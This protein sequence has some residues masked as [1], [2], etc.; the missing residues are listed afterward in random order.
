MDRFS[1]A[2]LARRGLRGHR[3]AH[4][5]VA[6]GV[7]VATTV[8]VGA[9]VVGDSVR[10]SLRDLTLERLGA[11]DTAIVPG[12]LFR[13]ALANEAE[14]APLL[15]VPA[16][17]SR[18]E[19][20]QTKTAS[21]V[22]L[23]GCDER[24]FDLETAQSK[25]WPA[26]DDGAFITPAIAAELGDD[27]G[28]DLIVRSTIPTDLPADSPLGE[29]SDT[30]ASVR[31]K[32]EAVTSS[33]GLAR[34]ALVPSQGE[35]RNVFVPLDVAQQLLDA[36]GQCN[37]L[38][39]AGDLGVQPTLADYGLSLNEV[40]PGVWQ[41]ESSELVL[42]D[43]VEVAASRAFA[44]RPLVTANTYLANTIRIGER[45]IPYSTVA[46]VAD[47][48]ELSPATGLAD[49]EIAL[50]RWAADDLRAS[51]G[52]TVTL[53]YYEPE[54]THGVLREAEPIELRLARIV[55]LTD[56]SGEPTIAN[57][58]RWTPQL[59]GVT[60]A[61]SIN[62]WDLPF[63]LVET[64][65]DADEDYWDE[66]GTTPK[67]FV[68]LE[69]AKR[70]WGTRW[71]DTS[72]VRVAAADMPADEI[73]SKLLA[74]IDP[75]DLGFAPVPIKARG[76]AAASGSTP[77][78]VL[79]LLFSF[80]LIGAALLLIV[81]LVWLA[82]DGRRREL[83]VLGAVG[84]DR[85]T[86]RRLMRKEF[87]PVAAVGAL[88]GAALGVAYA[89]GL[90][91]LLRTV[92]IDAVGA[93]FLRLHAGA[94]PIIGG[95]IGAWLVALV[96]I[97]WALRRAT[98][99]SPKTLLA[100][101]G[102]QP[103]AA[104]DGSPRATTGIALACAALAGV[105]I[106]AGGSLR[107]E[108]AAGV[109]FA[110]GGLTLAA[111]L[112]SV[113]RMAS[114]GGSE[115]SSISL[116]RLA[117]QNVRRR[118]GRSLLTIGLI[119]AA[120]F[121]LLATSA[122]RLPP[123]DAG[124]GGFDLVAESDQP[125][126]YDLA[127]EDG[128]WELGFGPKAEDQLADAAIYSFRTHAGEDASCRNLYQTR[129]P[130]VLGARPRFAAEADECPAPFV[131]A[132]TAAASEA[133]PWSVLAG[134]VADSDA[135][136]VVLDFNTAVYSLKLYGGVGSRFTIRDELGEP[137]TVELA[138]LLK[139]SVLQ[140]DL[141]M[142]EA[143]FLRHFPSASGSQFFLI[144]GGDGIAAELEDTLSDYGF[145]AVDAQ[146]RLAGFLAVQNTYLSTFQSLGGLGLLLGAVG[147]AIA[148]FRNLLERRGELALMRASGFAKPRLRRLVLLENLT[149]LGIG[150]AAGAIAAAATL[151]PLAA[152]SEARP[153]WLSA[154]ALIAATIAI[155]LVAARLAAGR[156]L[157]RPVTAALR[158]E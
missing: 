39:A 103:S 16:T 46:G 49:D 93:P 85:R 37:T 40:R 26:L 99:V 17:L 51:V 20:G 62:D 69:L 73:E 84:F 38:V 2:Q 12:R 144:R 29:K 67:A 8:L 98:G 10:G 15:I 95:A 55:E 97:F 79:F 131:W 66:Y 21:R 63:E 57:D 143:D 54:S 81:L 96:T 128:R 86:L 138:G 34:F 121:L 147:L 155:G 91:Y 108:A 22:T 6:A 105:A 28:Y 33:R 36:E 42:S 133:S 112:A 156:A 50:T 3:A 35:P 111:L 77:F 32:V 74:R 116:G 123:T 157:S 119:A 70:F 126:H 136:P 100:G 124:T 101:E 52:D 90:L 82:I 64:I 158:V 125:L 135:V 44:E 115:G 68:S 31:V 140:G 43:T 45:T 118:P 13:D 117:S 102:S 47:S 58:P 27:V 9:L 19:D 65:R 92:W 150:L 30:V 41:L 4:A 109:F 110:A 5:A 24:F 148:Q 120:S 60:D 75:G 134:S 122:F 154:I 72:L 53:T 56:D 94:L 104:A 107:G 130:R 142:S 137:F 141:L 83:G 23:I 145:D 11:I 7:A 76:L 1:L 129:Q 106:L 89:A 152:A 14:A 59:E 153:P 78:D 132:E 139:N 88:A 61:E 114:G 80:F 149:L 87:A 127:S 25:A 18:R 151:A 113:N 71:G 48:P 146:G